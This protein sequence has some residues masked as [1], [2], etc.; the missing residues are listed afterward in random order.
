MEN[1]SKRIEHPHHELTLEHEILRDKGTP[2]DEEAIEGTIEADEEGLLGRLETRT[3]R[4]HIEITR[5]ALPLEV[6]LESTSDAVLSPLKTRLEAASSDDSNIWSGYIDI[7]VRTKETDQV[8]FRMHL[9]SIS[10]ESNKG[11]YDFYVDSIQAYEWASELLDRNFD[12]DIFEEISEYY[13]SDDPINTALSLLDDTISYLTTDQF[14]RLLNVCGEII[15][16]FRDE[17]ENIFTP[18][19]IA[20]YLPGGQRD[21]QLNI[22]SWARLRQFCATSEQLRYTPTYTQREIVDE[23]ISVMIENDRSLV[24][25]NYTRLWA[26]EEALDISKR[27]HD[28]IDSQQFIVLLAKA[29]SEERY[30]LARELVIAKV[31]TPEEEAIDSAIEEAKR[32]DDPDDW[33]KSL[34]LAAAS[35]EEWKTFIYTL[36]NFLHQVSFSS[37]IHPQVSIF[38]NKVAAELYRRLEIESFART[39][40]FWE[41]YVRGRRGID[42]EQFGQARHDLHKAREL[43]LLEIDEYGKDR[44]TVLSLAWISLCQAEMKY[45]ININDFEEAIDYLEVAGKAVEAYQGFPTRDSREYCRLRIKSFLFEARGDKHL[46]DQNYSEAMN[47]YGKAIGNLQALDE[48]FENGIRYLKNRRS[49]IRASTLEADG[50]YGDASDAYN[51]IEE[52]SKTVDDFVKFHRT[53]SEICRIKSLIVNWEVKEAKRLIDNVEYKTEVLVKELEQIEV[54]LDLLEQYQQGEI[55]DIDEA[56]RTLEKLESAESDH[57]DL[58]FGYGHDYRPAFV[59]LIAAQRLKNIIGPREV[60]D[61]LVEIALNDVLKPANVDR[62]INREGLNHTSVTEEWKDKVPDFITRQI[63]DVRQ[64]AAGRQP[65]GN[66]AAE[67][68]SLTGHL[69]ECAEIFVAYH[70]RQEHGVDWQAQIAPNGNVTLKN[71]SDYMNKDIFESDEV[72]SEVR[73]LMSKTAFDDIVLEKKDG[74]I[75]DVRNDLAHNNVSNISEEEYKR[76]K[77]HIESILAVLSKEIA[78]LGKVGGQNQYDAYSVRLLTLDHRDKIDVTTDAKLDQGQIYFFPKGIVTSDM[79]KHVDE[80]AVQPLR[81]DDILESIDSHSDV[82]VNG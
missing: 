23:A 2:T 38:I 40:Q 56:W 66:Y 24:E 82:E 30:S 19:S 22:D 29:A 76:V 46:R 64:G 37:D 74:T 70:A 35:K 78:V 75:V 11:S 48:D 50:K 28:L 59:Y 62:I 9:N 27:Y 13:E 26:L 32:S 6:G 14:L 21:N 69:E 17:V 1:I 79:V 3:Q 71:I 68:E 34:Q 45:H 77:D 16:E 7:D 41:H 65:S 4:V 72:A 58:D 54:L 8:S 73:N 80:E 57:A 63:Q 20:H 18:N 61:S 43:S 53:R 12:L 47:A 49:A 51:E 39:A 31:S 5:E 44:F 60:F 55:T 42:L 25:R 67:L 15:P 81:A 52:R 10:K 36:A 33:K